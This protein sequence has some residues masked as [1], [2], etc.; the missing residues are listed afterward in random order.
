[1]RPMFSGKSGSKC[2]P[3]TEI[4]PW[5][6]AK[7]I[8]AVSA[9]GEPAA[10]MTAVRAQPVRGGRDGVGG[11]VR[12]DRG[13]AEALRERAPLGD[14]VHR[15]DGPGDARGEQDRHQAD[16]A[17]AHDDRDVTGARGPRA[18]SPS[19]RWA[20]CR[21]TNTA[22]SSVTPSGMH[23]ERA[24]RDRH[25]HELGLA[26]VRAAGRRPSSRTAPGPGTARS[27]PHG[28]RCSVR[29][30]W[31]SWPRPGRRA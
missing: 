30:R 11:R 31:W 14:A 22:C 12:G 26:A 1:M 5:P 23:L 24:V 29:T 27:G 13:G 15:D 3:M 19:S 10:S 20:A 6:R 25:P 7:P 4:V 18:G 17:A 21:P 8:A 28:R 2:A 16:G 9:P